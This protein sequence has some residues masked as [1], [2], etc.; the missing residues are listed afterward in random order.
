MARG[1]LNPL[2][3]ISKELFQIVESQSRATG[4]D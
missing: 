3:E 2:T 4:K 1:E